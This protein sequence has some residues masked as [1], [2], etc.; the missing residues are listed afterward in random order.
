M[1]FTEVVGRLFLVEIQAPENALGGIYGVLNQKCGH[2]F[3]EMQ[4]PGTRLYNIKAYLPVVESFGLFVQLRSATSGEAFP[5]SVFDH[6]DATM[7]DPLQPGIQAT[8]FA[9]DIRKRKEGFE[10]SDVCSSDV[11]DKL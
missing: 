6:W 1:P 2:V 4:R 11:V 3:E 8:Y 9:A 5:Q 7:A 10:G